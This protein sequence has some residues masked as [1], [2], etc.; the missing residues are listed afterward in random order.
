MRGVER[1]VFGVGGIVVYPFP[2]QFQDS[3]VMPCAFR[4]KGWVIRNLTV[5]YLASDME[6]SQGNASEALALASDSYDEVLSRFLALPLFKAL[7]FSLAVALI[8]FSGNGN[9]LKADENFGPLPPLY[10]L[11]GENSFCHKLNDR[12][13]KAVKDNNTGVETGIWDNAAAEVMGKD[14]I[15]ERHGIVFESLR[16]RMTSQFKTKFFNSFIRYMRFT[17]GNSVGK[18]R[19]R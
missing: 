3:F 14:F 5:K 19:K 8:I 18:D 10:L 2:D 4:S 13:T 1:D 15:S 9:K 11:W 6:L 16:K 7:Q 12:H 17:Y